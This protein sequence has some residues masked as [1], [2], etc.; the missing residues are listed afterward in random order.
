VAACSNP[1]ESAHIAAANSNNIR[2]I[3]PLAFLLFINPKIN[4]KA[5]NPERDRRINIKLNSMSMFFKN[6]K[7]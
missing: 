6:L 5:R 2:K 4:A 1:S 7:K 3:T